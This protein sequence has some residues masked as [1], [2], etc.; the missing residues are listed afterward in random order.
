MREYLNEA[1]KGV[2]ILAILAT[3][4]FTFVGMTPPI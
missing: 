3:I 1:A 2:V 4:G